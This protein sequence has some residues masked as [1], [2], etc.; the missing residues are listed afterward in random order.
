M[1]SGEMS[2][3]EFT[4]FLT[5]A[6][7]QMSR[8]SA[9]GA[10]G[11]WFIDFRHMAELMAA[12]NAAYDRL[13]NLCV[14][15]KTNA[16]MGSLYRSQHE[17]IFVY[18]KGT[19]PHINNVELGKNG[20]YR[21]NLWVYPGV[22]SFGPGRDEALQSHPTSKP[23]QLLSDVALDV[24]HRGDIIAD[25]FLGSGSTLIATERTGRICYG[26][27]L[28]PGYIDV[29]VRRW[30]SISGKRAILAG[31]DMNIDQLAIERGIGRGVKV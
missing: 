27:E 23:V 22:N 10:L 19:A 21:S 18:K 17:L 28:D 1:A 29:T 3:G 11:F 6:L 16:G 24:T 2:S 15:A 13:I 20:R 25:G 12:G 7:K 30:E 8:I 4:Q 9:D 5:E 31:T 26:V 14:W